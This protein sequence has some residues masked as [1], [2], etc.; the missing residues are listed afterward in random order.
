MTDLSPYLH[1]WKPQVPVRG[2]VCWWECSCL[3]TTTL[4]VETL[5]PNKVA[6]LADKT[7]RLERENE[8]L[9]SI[10]FDK[11]TEDILEEE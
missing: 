8:R 9:R 4:P 5:C 7:D 10:M 3:L 11:Q 1:D 6:K 2:T